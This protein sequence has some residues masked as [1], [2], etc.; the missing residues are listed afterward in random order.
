[1]CINDESA[2]HRELYGLCPGCSEAERGGRGGWPA[3]SALLR[4]STFVSVFTPSTVYFEHR[5]KNVLLNH[6]NFRK[7]VSKTVGQRWLI[8]AVA[9]EMQEP[10][11]PPGELHFLSHQALLCP[12][13]LSVW[14]EEIREQTSFCSHLGAHSVS[15]LT[16]SHCVFIRTIHPFILSCLFVLNLWVFFIAEPQL[17]LPYFI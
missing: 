2:L 15:F 7:Q 5:A 10:M 17:C 11:I 4:D 12:D 9:M 8:T 13:F 6:N 1:M 16:I 14:G 3:G